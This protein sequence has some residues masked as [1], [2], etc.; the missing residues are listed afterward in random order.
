MQLE[1]PGVNNCCLMANDVQN[2]RLV[3]LFIYINHLYMNMM[4][5]KQLYSNQTSSRWKKVD[6]MKHFT[7]IAD[8][9]VAQKNSSMVTYL[10]STYFIPVYVSFI[11]VKNCGFVMGFVILAI[12][13][14]LITTIF[15]VKT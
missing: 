1:T 9:N 7:I 14:R 6:K 3:H 13:F 15:N 12:Y 5:R 11:I 10:F 2:S 4:N 8:L